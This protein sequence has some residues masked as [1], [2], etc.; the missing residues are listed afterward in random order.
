[1]MIR[2]HELFRYPATAFRERGRVFEYPVILM[3]QHSC[4]HTSP[5]APSIEKVVLNLD[6]A[7]TFD[8]KNCHKSSSLEPR[9]LIEYFWLMQFLRS[10]RDRMVEMRHWL[11]P[12]A[13]KVC[14]L[15]FLLYTL[16]VY[17]HSLESPFSTQKAQDQMLP[18]TL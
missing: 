6:V 18:Q 11:A 4:G 14:G 1:M 13:Q 7:T 17:T 3:I 10:Y 15:M 5:S 2:N 12:P 8:R 16:F 9:V